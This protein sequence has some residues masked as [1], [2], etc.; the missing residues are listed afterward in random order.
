MRNLKI[1]VPCVVYPNRKARIDSSLR[2]KIG[3]DLF[4]FSSA[5]AMRLFD[6]NP[7]RYVK[8]LSDPVT[9]SRFKVTRATPRLEYRER[10]YYF[11]SDSTR[12]AFEADREKYRDRRA[13]APVMGM[14]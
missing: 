4:Y 6:R 12:H 5:Q 13:A 14:L 8:A 7:A 1:E 11:A 9:I 10:A 3:H 2:R